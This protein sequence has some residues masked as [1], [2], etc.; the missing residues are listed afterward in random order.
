MFITIKKCRIC[1]NQ[2]FDYILNLGNQPPANSLQ[3]KVSNQKKIPLK[4]IRCKSCSTLQLNVTV[5]P[6]HLFSKYIW[7][8]G[9]SDKI[10]DYRK[11]FVHK[12]LSKN[13]KKDIK[14]LEIASNDGFFLEEFKKK[15]VEILGV[16]PA[17]NISKKAN[18]K[19]IKTL[20]IFFNEKNSDLILKK[21][22]KPNIIICRNVVPHVENI[23]S[24]MRGI[25]NILDENGKVY[26]EF[27]YAENLSKK[28]HYD[29]IYHEHIFYFT[30][31]SM[32]KIL[33]KHHL[34]PKDY[35]ESPISGGSIVLEVCKK[36]VSESK[37]LINLKKYEKKENLNTLKY[38]MNFTKKCYAHNLELNKQ[39]D[40]Y[41]KHEIIGYGASARSSTLLNYCG[42]NS[43][44]IKFIFD[45]NTLKHNLFT[46]GTNIQIKKPNKNYLRNIKCV[47]VLA[48]N[49]KNEIIKFLKNNLRFKGKLIIVL[50]KIKVINVN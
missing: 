43:K 32:K 22:L 37:K 2:K 8:T 44:K 11:F 30:Y 5:K 17:R 35:F 12:I 47:V 27:H 34:Y 6:K 41:K 10:K 46:A 29:Y 40:K 45:K 18:Q 3:R 48:W 16:D 26:V 4:V 49:F 23:G 7:V 42:I 14:L 28:L 39:V 19:G 15:K 31:L 36:K 1:S 21:H 9:T 33:N 38:W 50:P 25:S 20:P 24:L 13:K